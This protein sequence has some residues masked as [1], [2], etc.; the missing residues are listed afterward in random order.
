[1]SSEQTLPDEHAAA[2]TTGLPPAT[3]PQPVENAVV[4]AFGH[5]SQPAPTAQDTAGL[6]PEA[7]PVNH[8]AAPHNN[9]HSSPADADLINQRSET[10]NGSFQAPTGDE[11]FAGPEDDQ[12]TGNAPVLYPGGQTADE[13]N[14]EVDV[15][16]TQ[17][18]S[19][20]LCL[21]TCRQSRHSYRDD[22]TT[23]KPIRRW[24][25]TRSP[26]H[27]PVETWA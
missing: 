9:L 4:S 19:T 16:S 2:S 1:M 7:L 14:L 11:A 26:L 17:R 25:V 24:G 27:H 18:L 20:N 12:P 6:L 23:S 22:R 21:A 5:E 15:R 13:Q 8:G 3:Q 10:Q